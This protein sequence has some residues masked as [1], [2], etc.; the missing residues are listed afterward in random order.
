LREFAGG[1]FTLPCVLVM[2]RYEA[3]ERQHLNDIL[4][5]TGVNV[6]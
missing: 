1:T 6:G 3:G 4:R 2:R 5:E